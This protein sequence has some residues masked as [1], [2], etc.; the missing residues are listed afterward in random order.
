MAGATAATAAGV[1]A[2]QASAIT[3]NLTN[4]FISARDGN[5]LNADLTGDGKLD[6][7]LTG[8]TFFYSY[9]G[10]TKY[11]FHFARYSAGVNI[12]GVVVRGYDNGDY[13]F[14]SV[15]LGLQHRFA[16]GGSSVYL[17]GSI[18][19]SFKDLHINNGKL[20]NGWLDVT[21]TPD[22]VQFDDY[23]YYTPDQGSTLALLAMGAAG[24]LSLRRW[25]TAPERT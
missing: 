13:P 6:I 1:G 18:P 5:H 25:R 19:V 14:R 22:K 2:S 11:G 7:T 20:T 23:T 4:N 17:T 24:V 9:R 15:T 16:T 8:A 3:I 21:V 10:S 12:N